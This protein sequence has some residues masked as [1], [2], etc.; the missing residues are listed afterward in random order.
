MQKQF[1]ALGGTPTESLLPLLQ[2]NLEEISAAIPDFRYY[3]AGGTMHTILLRPEVYSYEVAG[4]R[5]VDWLTELAAG[6]PVQN[7][8]CVD[9]T[10]APEPVQAP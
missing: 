10:M 4:V 5:F 2:G 1:L 3:V 7:V 9:C 6:E 8:M